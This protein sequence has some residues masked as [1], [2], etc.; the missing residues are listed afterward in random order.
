MLISRE[1]AHVGD[2][3][4]ALALIEDS[5]GIVRSRKLAAEHANS[6]IEH[7]AVL[8]PSEC[9]QALTNMADYVLSRLY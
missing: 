5:Q 1:F 6:A 2:L 4:Q 9:R 8:P 3:D 7:L